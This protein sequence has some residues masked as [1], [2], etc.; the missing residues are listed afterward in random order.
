MDVEIV[1]TKNVPYLQMPLY[2]NACDVLILTST[3]EGSPNVVKEALACNLP[4]VA[5]NVGDIAT[6]LAAVDGCVLCVD[7]RVETLAAGLK[8]ALNRSAMFDGRSSVLSLDE[9]LTAARVIDIY[10][11]A[12]NLH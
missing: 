4:V 7:H 1:A 5:V 8:A 9:T 2:M 11:C 12:M 3:H 6:R 10:G